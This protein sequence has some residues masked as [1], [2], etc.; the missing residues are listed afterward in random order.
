MT[1]EERNENIGKP[2]KTPLRYHLVD[3]LKDLKFGRPIENQI[4]INRWIEELNE[5]IEKG[6]P[7]H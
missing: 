4:M 3:C 5:N 6:I 7:F 1:E 2:L